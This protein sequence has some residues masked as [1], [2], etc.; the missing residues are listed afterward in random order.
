MEP[1]EH[2]LLNG[3][4]ITLAVLK[5]AARRD[6]AAAD[7]VAH[8][9]A[10]LRRIDAAA[11]VP[12]GE[13]DSRVTEAIEKLVV[14][15]L[16][17]ETGGGRYR[18]TARGRRMLSEHPQGVDDSVLAQFRTFRDFLRAAGRR[19]AAAPQPPDDADSHYDA[20]FAAY[21]AGQSLD[22]NPHDDDAAAHLDWDDGWGEAFDE[23]M[24]H[25]AHGGGAR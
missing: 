25:R 20:G 17:Q 6:I 23:D 5:E 16:L 12:P 8:V 4:S 9:E 1:S 24:D 15:A 22:A 10:V 13:I 3:P 21:H 11:E 14:A 7:G 19:R 2:P 18:I